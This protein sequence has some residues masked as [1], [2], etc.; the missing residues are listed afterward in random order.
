MMVDQLHT[1]AEIIQLSNLA[2]ITEGIVLL[3]IATIVVM[4]GLGFLQKSWQRYVLPG[5]ALFASIVLIGFLFFDHLN[6]LPLAWKWITTDMQ[7]RQHLQMGVL[8]GVGSLVAL[9]GIKW[10]KPK[11]NLALHAA[12]AL[13][14]F[15]FIVHPQHGSD[16]EAAKALLIHRVAGTALIIAGI[17][18]ATALFKQ[19]WR[20]ALLIL[21]GV[22]LALSAVLFMAYREPSMEHDMNMQPATNNNTNMEHMSH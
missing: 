3:I 18:Q 14:G 10:Q 2:H 6:E 19:Q 12:I 20:K 5:I 11:L 7:Q 16:A 1:P 22:C 8:L 9:I 4:Q 17:A 15:L 13:I 21:A